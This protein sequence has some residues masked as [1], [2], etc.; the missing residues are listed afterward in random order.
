MEKNIRIIEAVDRQI[1]RDR[2][3]WSDLLEDLWPLISLFIGK[4]FGMPIYIFRH[5]SDIIFDYSGTFV[6]AI[7]SP[8]GS[9]KF[10]HPL[11][12]LFTEGKTLFD[13]RMLVKLVTFVEEQVQPR[14]KPHIRGN[15]VFDY[16]LQEVSSGMINHMVESLEI[17]KKAT[18]G[19]NLLIE[20]AKGEA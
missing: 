16:T 8:D 9:I 13:E 10:Y 19:M 6:I 20:K 17:T 12:C 1:L 7:N 11:G 3:M 5:F 4:A 14:K 15:D 2:K 18:I